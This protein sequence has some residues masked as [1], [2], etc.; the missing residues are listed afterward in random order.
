MK[1][2]LLLSCC[3]PAIRTHTIPKGSH[4]TGTSCSL[5]GIVVILFEAMDVNQVIFMAQMAINEGDFPGALHLLSLGLA[6]LA[7]VASPIDSVPF[8][9]QRAECYWQVGQFQAS[10]TD[11]EQAIR[12]GL[13]R[14]FNNSQEEIWEWT[15]HGFSL[16]HNRDY[17]L[18][19]KCVNIAFYFRDDPWAQ[20]FLCRALIRYELNNESEAR[21]DIAVLKR[22]DSGLAEKAAFTEKNKAFEEFKQRNYEKSLKLFRLALLLHPAQNN[23][24][25]VKIKRSIESHQADASFKLQKYTQALEFGEQS[26]QSNSTL[27]VDEAKRWKDRGNKLSKDSS[28]VDMAIRCYSLALKYAPLKEKELIGTILSNRCSM[29]IKK[30]DNEAALEDARQSVKYKPDWAKAHYRL[31]SCLRTSQRLS[32]ARQSFSRSLQLLLKDTTTVEHRKEDTFDQLLSVVAES[33]DTTSIQFKIPQNLTQKMIDKAIT[34]KDWNRLYVLFMGGGGEK[35][36]KKGSGG[37]GTGCDAR[38][39]PL[40]EIIHCDFPH[41][42]TFMK[43]LL[44]H[45]AVARKDLL[46]V[47]TPAVSNHKDKQ[48]DKKEIN[49]KQAVCLNSLSSVKKLKKNKKRSRSYANCTLSKKISQDV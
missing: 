30:G 6:H 8:L 12:A 13:P 5:K 37:L 20:T 17:H 10:V 21:E 40:E 15:D 2:W 42:E 49:R 14:E 26:Y 19:E 28:S 1:F 25:W 45:N 39:I 11:M 31:G 9:V 33:G 32:E 24:S 4:N 23:S 48:Q 27:N 7:N 16:Y 41:L 36:F 47:A 43:I 18:A 35:C 22:L 3:G 38:N 29:Y 46:G 44:D 34:D